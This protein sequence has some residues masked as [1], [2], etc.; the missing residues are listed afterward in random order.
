MRRLAVLSAAVL[1]GVLSV[2]PP[3]SALERPT[4]RVEDPIAKERA[5]I[6]AAQ[7]AGAK[8]AQAAGGCLDSGSWGPVTPMTS[9][10]DALAIN[11]VQA[12]Q[13]PWLFLPLVVSWGTLVI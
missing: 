3:A 11:C 6:T 13:T 7:A 12:V 8:P 4:A 10:A 1:L 2:H 9:G 5:C